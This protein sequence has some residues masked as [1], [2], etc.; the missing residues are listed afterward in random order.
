MLASSPWLFYQFIYLFS[1]WITALP[2]PLIGVASIGTTGPLSRIRCYNGLWI[3]CLQSHSFDHCSEFISYFWSIEDVCFI[4]MCGKFVLVFC[5]SILSPMVNCIKMW[6]HFAIL[7][8]GL[9]DCL[10]TFLSHHRTFLVSFCS[11]CY[12]SLSYVQYYLA[13]LWENF[14][15]HMFY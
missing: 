15:C 13:S 3:N 1:L 8:G 4:F 2:T 7:T 9:C 11:W 14:S 5:F 10:N 12:G 6:A